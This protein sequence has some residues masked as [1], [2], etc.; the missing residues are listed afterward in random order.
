MESESY[1]KYL[2]IMKHHSHVLKKDV[3]AGRAA[4]SRCAKDADLSFR[5]NPEYVD[6]DNFLHHA[7]QICLT[8]PASLDDHARITLAANILVTCLASQK[9]PPIEECYAEIQSV[10]FFSSIG[11]FTDIDDFQRKAIEVTQP[12]LDQ[13]LLR[14]NLRHVLK[15]RPAPPVIVKPPTPVKP[16]TLVQRGKPLG[17]VPPQD[18][19]VFQRNPFQLVKQQFLMTRKGD[20]YSQ[21]VYVISEVER[22]LTGEWIVYLQTED[23]WEADG[24][25]LGSV[26]NMIRHSRYYG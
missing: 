12:Q 14:N 5:I 9:R 18:I 15:A 13:I 16:P 7:R 23:H 26:L 17:E 24:M 4:L 11:F 8:K 21:K 6:L 22:S 10:A 3:E 19:Q 1:Q 2:G 25:V 20:Q